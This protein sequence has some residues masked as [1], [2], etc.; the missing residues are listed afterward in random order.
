M[1]A[2]SYT[3]TPFLQDD[4]LAV[5]RYHRGILL[6]PLSPSAEHKLRWLATFERI[7]GALHLGGFTV[8]KNELEQFLTHPSKRPQAMER[9]VSTYKNSLLAVRMDW[10]ANPKSL[11]ASHI[12]ALGLIALPDSARDTMRALR[13]RESDMKHLLSYIA[14]QK[15]HPLLLAGVLY[16]QLMQTEIGS[17]T[18]GLLPRLL[19]SLILAKYGYDCRGMLA[20]EPQWIAMKEHHA[21]ALESI[22][23]HGQLT[24]W[25]EHFIRAARISFETLYTTVQTRESTGQH[26]SASLWLLN[27]REEQILYELEHPAAKITN[28]N[29]QH[30]FHISQV[31]A[32]RDLAHLTAL[33]LLYAHGKGRSVYYTKA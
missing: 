11:A 20:L 10:T 15:D 27:T 3:V 7:Y 8:P 17:N 22:R 32:S 30:R 6:T 28:R 26:V 14:S 18:R 29:M 33:G 1:I 12:G 9:L 24:V 16:G 25:L 5:D 19:V 4:L 13:E 2:I 21:K 23:T 31:T